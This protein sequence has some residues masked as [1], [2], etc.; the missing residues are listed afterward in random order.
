[1]FSAFLNPTILCAP[2]A[3]QLFFGK[4][5]SVILPRM[6]IEYIDT[7][8]HLYLNAFENDLDAVISRALHNG[9]RKIFLPNLDQDSIEPM[10]RIC[11]QYEGICYPMI[12]LH[13]TSVKEDFRQQLNAMTEHLKMERCIAV[14]ETGIDLYW[15]KKYLDQQKE[16]F[17]VHIR[18][19]K[20]FG[21]PLVIHARESFDEIFS[22]MDEEYS[23]ELKGVFHSFAGTAGQA[24]KILAYDF[25]LGINGIVTFRNSSLAEISKVIPSDRILLETDAPFLAPAPYRGKRNESAYIPEIAAGLAASLRMEPAEL[26][27][28]TTQNSKRLFSQSGRY[29]K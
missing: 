7:H 20:E 5:E 10:L 23:P 4:K 8:A 9:V 26:A 15:D 2:A 28:I 24:E 6:E 29:E 25:Y 14:G 13:P 17:R 22:V 12:G 21:L 18:W 16:S 3:V 27:S 11:S 19:A 1:M